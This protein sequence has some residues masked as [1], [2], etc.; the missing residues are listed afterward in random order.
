LPRIA[1][2]FN[3]VFS[4]AVVYACVVGL[5]GRANAQASITGVVK[6]SSGGVLPGVTVEASSAALIEKTRQATTDGTG[7]YQ[8]LDLGPGSYTVIFALAGFNRVRHDVELHGS[9]VATLDVELAVGTVDE[10]ITVTGR[11]SGVDL[12]SPTRQWIVRHDVIDVV[13]TG[14]SERSI[15]VL[16]PGIVATTCAG[17]GPTCQDVGGALADQ[18]SDLTVHGSTGVDQ[19]VTQSGL[20]LGTLARGGQNA[21]ALPNFAAI[22]EVTIDSAG[23]SPEMA[24][25]GVRINFIPRDGGNVFA[26]SLFASATTHDLQSSNFTD[27]LRSRGLAAADSVKR[28][29]DINPGFGGPLKKDALWIFAAARANGAW[30]YAGGI[31]YNRNA[32]NPIAWSYEPDTSR[33]GSN[34]TTWRDAQVR[35]TWQATPKNKIGLSYGHQERCSCPYLVNATTSPEAGADFKFPVEN[36]VIVD[37]SSPITRR[38]LLEGGV[39]HRAE[40]FGTRIPADLN[41][42]MI[43]ATDQL[44]LLTYRSRPTY[45]DTRSATVYWRAALSY[46]AGPHAFNVGF[47]RGSGFLENSTYSV[48]PV[49]YRLLDGSPNLLTEYATPY[50]GRIDEDADLGA[51]IRDT[52]TIRRLTLTVGARYDYF[53]NSSPEQSV[54]P[55]PLTPNRSITFPATVGVTWHDITPKLGASY[56]LIGDGKTAL[57]FTLNKYVAGQ[58]LAGAFGQGL[59]PVNRLVNSTTR[60]WTDIN[61]DFIPNCDLLNPRPN[62]ECRMMADV[63]FGKVTPAISYDPATLTG[64][65]RRSYNWELSAGIQRALAARV[66]LDV[67]FYRRWYG[68]FIVTDNTAISPSD[69]DPYSIRAPLDPRLPGGGGYL[70]SGLYDLTPSKVGLVANEITFSDTFGSQMQH[71]NGVDGILTA[72]AGPDLL[73]QGGISVGRTVTDTC[74]VVTKVNNPSPLYCHQD[75]GLLPQIKVLGAYMIPRIAVQISGALQSLSGPSLSAFYIAANTLVAPSLGRNLSGGAPNVTINLIAPGSMYGDRINQLDLRIGKLLR[76]GNVHAIPHVDL[77]NVSNA[78]PVLVESSAFASWRQPQSILLARLMKL[79]IQLEF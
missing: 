28:N 14:R 29:W 33:Q 63:N 51:Y 42:A 62:G 18:L 60:V 50:G 68:N 30:N 2:R 71:W 49:S 10:I 3:P 56:D 45:A 79:G 27:D 16:L 47:N 64:W 73:I 20:S 67:S 38:L 58:A 31:F 53:R 9:F 52:W 46:I 13:P 61:K 65:G 59:S 11:V 74:A 25:G 57:K 6:D 44:T 39:I 17:G 24:T 32:N 7:H 55:A 77:Y 4:I 1:A 22:Q 37:W 23:V 8:I 72:H 34:N 36:N 35:L 19:R 75:S 70:I 54:G 15:A 12:R 66:L 26:G 78:N 43:S 5:P 69:Y 41:P 40:G 48:Q 76:M 21:F